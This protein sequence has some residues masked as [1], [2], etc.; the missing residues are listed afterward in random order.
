MGPAG[1]TEA[2]RKAL[3]RA[4]RAESMCPTMRSGAPTPA[5]MVEILAAALRKV[6]FD[7][8]F[9]GAD[10]SDGQGG[11]VGAAV[12]TRWGCPTSYASEI[13]R[14]ATACASSHHQHPDSPP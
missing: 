13:Q 7:L 8:A 14:P 10:T 4:L 6:S 2:L 11:V 5:P 12:A 9:A 3:A 1:A